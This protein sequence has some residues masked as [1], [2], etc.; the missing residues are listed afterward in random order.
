MSG[1]RIPAA[2]S[3]P[4]GWRIVAQAARGLLAIDDARR[5]GLLKG[6]PAID[7]RQCGDLL[8]CAAEHGVTPTED[9]VVVAIRDIITGFRGEA[10]DL[11]A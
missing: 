11:D 9:Q 8:A 6:G 5:A 2:P 10:V 1:F 3:T 7:R 4:E